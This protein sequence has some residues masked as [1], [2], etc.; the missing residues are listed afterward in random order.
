MNR[1]KLIIAIGLLVALA[2]VISDQGERYISREVERQL[3]AL[4]Q[5]ISGS[6]E[7]EYRQ[8]LVDAEFIAS[9][10]ELLRAAKQLVEQPKHKDVLLRSP[11]Q[12]LARDFFTPLLEHRVYEGFF[13]IGPGN[14]N[15]ASSHDANVGRT[16][17]LTT[18]PAVLVRAWAGQSVI[19]LPQMSDVALRDRDGEL[20]NNAPTVF[21]VTPV[22][23]PTGQVAVLLA[24]RLSLEH[25]IYRALRAGATG[26]VGESYIFDR[27]A[28]MLSDSRFERKMWASGRLPDGQTSYGNLQIRIPGSGE[29]TRMAR[30][31][32][33]GQSGVDTAGYQDYR[34]IPVV[35]AWRWLDTHGIGVAVEVDAEEA[36]LG[37][38][39]MQ[40]AVFGST[41]LA[42][43]LLLIISRLSSQQ[44]RQLQQEVA[45]RT[46]ELYFEQAKL[47]GLF[48]QAPNGLIILDARGRITDF[49][50]CAQQIFGQMKCEVSGRPLSD[51]FAEPMPEFD[52]EGKAFEF[53]INTRRAPGQLVPLEVAVSRTEAGEHGF[54]LVI[55][56]DVS[57]AKQMEHA[58]RDEMRKRAAV[59]SRQRLLLEAAGEGIFGIDSDGR[60][61]FINPAGAR[62]LGYEPEELLGRRLTDTGAGDPAVCSANNP[63]AQ[64]DDMRDRGAEETILCRRDGSVFDAEYTRTQ[65]IA[66]DQYRGAVVIF[67]D[68]SARKSAEQS[69]MLAESVFQNITEGII[70]ADAQGR[71]LRVNRA[72]CA[73]VGFEEDELIGQADPP[74]QSGEHPPVFFQQLWDSLI[75]DG[76]W[77]GE[78]WNKRKN[79]RI[80]PT[81]QTIVA[82]RDKEGQ[83]VQYVSVARDITDQR[84]SERRIHRLAYFD[85][86]TG[87]PNREL[88]FDRF[89]HAIQRANRQGSSIA[90]LFLDLDRFKNVNDSLGHPVGDELLKSV[91]SRLKFLVRAEDTVARLGGDEFT[92]LLESVSRSE[93]VT[94]VAQ[95]VVEDLSRPFQIGDHHLHI[96]ASVGI[97]QYPDDG[98]D[99][100]TLVKHA[101]AAMYQAKAAGR[102]NFKFFNAAM[103]SRNSEQMAMEGHLHRAVHN[104]EFVLYYQPQ[105]A[106][107]GRIVGVEALI[108]WQHPVMGL[109]PPNKFIPIAEETGLIVPIGAWVLLTACQQMRQ[110]HSEGGPAIRVSVNLAGPQIMRGNIVQTVSDAL[111]T[112]GLDAEFLELEVTE[113]F[114]M[115][116]VEQSVG[117]LARLREL[118]VQ[119]AIDDFGTGHSSLATLKRLP[120]DTLKID[121]AF[122]R[123]IPKD[124]NDMAIA[125]AILAMGKELDLKTVAEGVE[126]REQQAF[127]DAE[128]CDYFQ[129]FLFSR[130]LPADTVQLLWRRPSQATEAV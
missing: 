3:S 109:V 58:M 110:W 95:K 63:I 101:D 108:R 26:K 4:L 66:H 87:L 45:A 67:S 121:R 24:L 92:V 130:P 17:L 5:A 91:A 34:G 32:T 29:L 62:F 13:L 90:L 27:D 85:N 44:E 83:P 57:Q 30:S 61:S 31:A 65:L 94:R 122:V 81:W 33:Q 73:M 54:Y 68:I 49:S 96:G 124:K 82:I 53:E 46:R 60:I 79:G 52:R 18:Q 21:A 35:G 98:T 47:N 84:R 59:E 75:H 56:R 129:G 48:R 116:H 113:T 78:I 40:A 100:T 71:I 14:S 114:V 74:Y 69:L 72:L 39:L 8:T 77:E 86:L 1:L 123:D 103:S 88:F 126:T 43:I 64:R 22:R 117:T 127:L 50:V 104:D 99:A 115:D 37:V 41:L 76:G 107:D 28:R 119:L 106:G 51:L 20:A 36:L 128:G 42:I 23:G 12:R 16:N 112:T 111:E 120:A 38:K 19:S 10:P 125:R 15:L 89:E 55:V 93:D 11:G 6:I 102:N 7:T 118:G 80:F 105:F 2:L 9:R 25:A 70:V 97:S